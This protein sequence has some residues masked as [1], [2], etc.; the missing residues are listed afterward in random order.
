MRVIATNGQVFR[1]RVDEALA[2]FHSRL[3]VVSLALFCC[4]LALV[5]PFI[6]G[7]SVI[8]PWRIAFW[9]VNGVV[10]V[11][12]WYAQFR[13]LARIMRTREKDFAVPSAIM[14]AVAITML[15]HFNYGVAGWMLGQPDI[16]RGKLYPDLFRYILVALVFETTVAM[17]VM[18]RLMIRLR[19]NA[20]GRQPPNQAAESQA[21]QTVTLADAVEVGGRRFELSRLLYIKSAEHYLEVVLHDTSDL[22]RARLRDAI[23]GLHPSQGVQPHRSFWVNRDAIV[24]LNRADG[25]QFL[26]LRNGQ[27]VP[28]SRHRRQEV[29]DWIERHVLEKR[30]GS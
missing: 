4:L 28:V 7:F 30:P 17:F 25:A 10:V 6:F 26:V 2:V 18:P 23:A 21:S 22:V 20:D 27:E 24:G 11:G 1:L 12:A 9:L 15:L 5:D 16:W 19:R 8:L 13:L 3:F 14:I 29:L